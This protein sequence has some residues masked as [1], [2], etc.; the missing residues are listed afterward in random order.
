M[1]AGECFHNTYFKAP[2]LGE[3]RY[4]FSIGVV[5]DRLPSAGDANTPSAACE[6]L[7]GETTSVAAAV[8]ATGR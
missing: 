1:N 2:D 3:T 6:G 4:H 5:P 8:D 7:A